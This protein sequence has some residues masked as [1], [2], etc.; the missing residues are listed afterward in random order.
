MVPAIATE[1]NNAP[2]ILSYE[3][4]T[5]IPVHAVLQPLLGLDFI[6]KGLSGQKPV[7][8]RP[9]SDGSISVHLLLQPLLGLDS[10]PLDLSAEKHAAS[11][12]V[13]TG[14]SALDSLRS[15]ESASL[16]GTVRKSEKAV[17]GRTRR[18][19]PVVS[20]LMERFLNKSKDK[21]DL[22]V[23][24]PSSPQREVEETFVE[25]ATTDYA[26]QVL[27]LD[28]VI[29][30]AVHVENADVSEKEKGEK[31][32]EVRMENPLEEVKRSDLESSNEEVEQLPEARVEKDEF[33]GVK[34]PLEELNMISLESSEEVEQLSELEGVGASTISPMRL[35]MSLQSVRRNVVIVNLK[36]PPSGPIMGR[37]Y[38]F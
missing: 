22:V 26:I 4:R 5:G 1:L 11:R 20:G 15:E 12:R 30:S 3:A 16:V 36:P 27:T 25:E 2:G 35:P 28:Q 8:S 31:D 10:L 32:E 7:A 37:I 33:V 18:R 24:A 17:K 38:D 6:P 29:S 9:V 13:S 19:I 21:V 14:T 23:T 34:N